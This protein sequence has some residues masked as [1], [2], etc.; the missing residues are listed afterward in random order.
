MHFILVAHAEAVSVLKSSG[1]ENIG[2]VLNKQYMAPETN[3]E[4]DNL[5]CQLS[6]EIHNLWFAEAIFKGQ[7][8]EKVLEILIQ[9]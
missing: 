5:A 7:Y 1:Q 6:D 4:N 3:S 8:P 9:V 2:I